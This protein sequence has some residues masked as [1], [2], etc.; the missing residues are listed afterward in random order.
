MR[1]L[2]SEVFTVCESNWPLQVQGGWWWSIGENPLDFFRKFGIQI[3]IKH[4]LGGMCHTIVWVF[5]WHTSHF[6]AKGWNS[7]LGTK[8]SIE[9]PWLSLFVIK[10]NHYQKGYRINHRGSPLGLE[11]APPHLVLGWLTLARPRR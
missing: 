5:Y 6:C 11:R 4:I 2:T 1:I 3:R 7:I 10:S 8:G 9:T